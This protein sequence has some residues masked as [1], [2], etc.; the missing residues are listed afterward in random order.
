ML[1]VDLLP[2]NR[3]RNTVP[4]TDTKQRGFTIVELMMATLVFSVIMLVAAG[5]VVRFTSNFQRGIAATNTQNAARSVIDSISQAV[6]FGGG[7]APKDLAKD[8]KPGW[9]V[10]PTRYSYVLGKQLNGKVD[11][12][13]TRYALVEDSTGITAC[14]GEAQNVA[15]NGTIAGQELLGENMRLV[16]FDITAA[17][18]YLGLWNVTIKV[19]YG[20]DEVLCSPSVTGSCDSN[21]KPQVYLTTPEQLS[22]PDLQCKVGTGNQYCAI[23]E[24]KTT[25][26]RR[27]Q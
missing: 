5:A 3:G 15:G 23:S 17:D 11:A 20:D 19:A 10:G 24:L 22:L 26:Q 8:S 25:V 12:T 21:V 27:V 18:A 4:N 14:G 16:K 2:T 7:N 9:C 1:M 6:Q 13:S